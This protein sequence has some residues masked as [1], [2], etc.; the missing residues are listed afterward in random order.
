MHLRHK[1]FYD[2]LFVRPFELITD[3]KPLLGLTKLHLHVRKE[4]IIGL[5]WNHIVSLWQVLQQ[6][7]DVVVVDLNV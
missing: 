7:K 6:V 5:L 1:R 4:K 3:H 2:Y